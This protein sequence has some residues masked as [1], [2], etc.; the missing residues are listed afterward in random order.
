MK[1]KK[2]V[3]FLFYPLFFLFSL[4]QLARVSFYHQQ[5]NGY[6]Y[7]MM[8]LVILFLL[9]VKYKIKPL[10]IAFYKNKYIFWFFFYCI[11][12]F[13]Y[14]IGDFTR[15]ENYIALLYQARLFFY[16]LA[17]FYLT[18]FLKKEK[19]TSRVF[20]NALMLFFS[21]TVIISFIQYFLYKDLRNLLYLG[22]D[23]HLYRIF[24][25]YL[26]P[27]VAAAIYGLAF[28]YLFFKRKNLFNYVLLAC[29]FIFI[30]LTFSRIGYVA[31]T[32]TLLLILLKKKWY[33]TVILTF[34]LITFLVVIIPKPQGEGVNLGRIFSVNSRIDDYRLAEKIWEK[35]PLIGIGY[36]RIR[37]IKERLN[38]FDYKN[39]VVSH[40]GAS[41]HS[42][43]IIILVC[44]GLIGLLVF[45][46][47]FI[48]LFWLTELTRYVFLYISLFSLADNVLLHPFVLFFTLMLVSLSHKQE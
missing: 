21:I 42:S 1:I 36:N 25:S 45:L 46:K 3:S 47:G 39:L 34:I 18:Y 24:G 41:F 38:I 19:L 8:M 10:T 17:F 40:A 43:F 32:V 11:M 29:Y 48:T 9:M 13:F 7:E 31:F 44:T 28:F 16:F 4:G 27:Y 30:F 22:W 26:D 37:Y 20:T 6:L 2:I 14:K 23:P 35:S 5:V 33:K 12:S 15:L